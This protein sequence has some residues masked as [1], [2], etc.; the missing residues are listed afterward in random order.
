MSKSKID[1]LYNA[2]AE[3]EF[4]KVSDIANEIEEG[5]EVELEDIEKLFD[6]YTMEWNYIEPWEYHKVE[7]IIFFALKGSDI[8][9]RFE[10][11]VENISNMISDGMGPSNFFNMSIY[12]FDEKEKELFIKKIREQGSTKD[13]V[14]YLKQEF[15]ESPIGNQELVFKIEE[16]IKDLNE[17]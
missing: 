14:N 7:D 1:E 12:S 17:V 11:F 16:L 9:K 4:D 8:E 10:I 15:L 6:I 3:E 2:I 5:I 13:I